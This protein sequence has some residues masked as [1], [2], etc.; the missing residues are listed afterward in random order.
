[1]ID[2][3]KELGLPEVDYNGQNQ[4]G[5]NRYQSTAIHGSRQSS[6]GAFI[7]PIRAQRSNLV[8][9]TNAVVNKILIDPK[10]K[11][12][13]GVEYSVTSPGSSRGGGDTIRARANKEVVVSGGVFESPKLLMLSGIG[14]RQELEKFGIE[15]VQDLPVG[16]NLQD[17]VLFPSTV[18]IFNQSTSTIV[19]PTEMKNDAVNWLNTHEG[20][21]E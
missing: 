1:M 7:R 13:Q 21:V 16:D 20:K 8:I 9:R 14:H 17:H 4:I 10:T 6:N 15:V 11:K 2:A 19:S 3:W 5:V 12:V 18:G